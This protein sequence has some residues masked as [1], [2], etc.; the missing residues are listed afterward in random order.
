M[1]KHQYYAGDGK[2]ETPLKDLEGEE[3][4]ELLL[5]DSDFKNEL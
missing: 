2:P 5:Q 4:L 1:N 3:F